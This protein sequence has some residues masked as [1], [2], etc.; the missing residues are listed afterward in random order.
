M[1]QEFDRTDGVHINRDAKAVV[2]DLRCSAGRFRAPHKASRSKQAA[3]R[4]G[5]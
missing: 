3:S 1:N 4:V 2:R 5:R